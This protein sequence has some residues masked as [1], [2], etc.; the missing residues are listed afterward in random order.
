MMTRTWARR[1][2]ART[3]PRKRHRARLIQTDFSEYSGR[4]DAVRTR[5]ESPQPIRRIG[6]PD[7]RSLRRTYLASDE[8]SF[9]TGPS[10]SLTAARTDG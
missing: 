10:W 2:S 1:S 7:E 5:I 8:A 9:I 4:N 3:G 6:H